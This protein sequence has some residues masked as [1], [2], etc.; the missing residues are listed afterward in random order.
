MCGKL[1][2]W[3][4][5]A[6]ISSCA[7]ARLHL[8]EADTAWHVIDAV[9]DPIVVTSFLSAYSIA[10]A[11]SARYTDA[12]SAAQALSSKS[13][14]LRFDFARPYALCG[15]AMAY[16]GQRQWSSAERAAAEA[17]ERAQTLHDVHA[18][19]LSR[20]VLLRLYAQQNQLSRALEIPVAELPRALEASVA[21]AAC[22]RALV[23]ACA[24]RIDDARELSATAT[25]TSRAVEPAVLV[26]AVA[27][28]CAIRGG[29]AD[30]V[31]LA[32]TLRES[33]FYTGAVDLLVTTY[34]ACPELLPVLLRES[35]GRRFRDLVE[36]VGDSDL[37]AAAGYP[38]A[39]N[40]DRRLLLSPRE[41]EV[42][43]LLRS[44][45]SNRQIA[46]LLFIEESTVKV[47]A[48]HIYDKLG[49]RSRS[50]LT[51]QAALERAQATSA[52]ETSPEEGSSEL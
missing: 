40:D 39:V 36:R 13:Q 3:R 5:T 38:I 30:S 31:E 37:A 4:R 12:A 49:V 7:P 2:E 35:D 20:S 27:A 15:M 10:L 51:V 33:A 26:P 14:Q 24:G 34:R 48:H 44:G 19:L 47:H 50:A 46:G 18:D 17:L 6:S 32:V 8:D 16:A 41:R 9:R 42:F 43:E 1:F 52:I 25:G 45:F 23:L 11:L 29:D 28:V 21:E 22:S